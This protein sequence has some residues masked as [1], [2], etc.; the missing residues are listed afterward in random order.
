[1]KSYGKI[2]EP[3][4]IDSGYSW[5]FPLDL[6]PPFDTDRAQIAYLD[7]NQKAQINWFD[8]MFYAHRIEVRGDEFTLQAANAG[9]LATIVSLVK[10]SL[11]Q[12]HEK[13]A[14]SVILKCMEENRINHSEHV[15]ITSPF[16]DLAQ[17]ILDQKEG[18][19][20]H[21]C[22]S[23][24]LYNEVV[25]TIA[26]YDPPSH[27]TGSF[28]EM[29]FDNTEIAGCIIGINA[30]CIMPTQGYPDTVFMGGTGIAYENLNFLVM[31]APEVTGI[32]FE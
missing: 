21:I 18:S 26:N 19:F 11:Y 25:N 7:E 10:D 13:L 14:T 30:E 1:M 23:H 32:Y 31:N 5:T 15:S 20:K 3:V 16:R 27:V 17:L 2:F 22:L 8:D 24:K 4:K 12:Q 6:V 29:D 28:L 9:E